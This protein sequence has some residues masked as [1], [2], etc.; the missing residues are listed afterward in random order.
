MMALLAFQG[1][2]GS[3][4]VGIPG[5]TKIRQMTAHT[6]GWGIGKFILLLIDMAGFTIGQSMHSQQRKIEFIVF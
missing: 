1:K 3:D 5:G 6:F 2:T 4:M